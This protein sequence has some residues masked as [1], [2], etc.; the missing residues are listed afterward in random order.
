MV[1]LCVCVC[2][3][4]SFYSYPTCSATSQTFSVEK[5]NDLCDLFHRLFRLSSFD[6][7]FV[8][9]VFFLVRESR[10]NLPGGSDRRDERDEQQDVP[11]PGKRVESGRPELRRHDPPLCKTIAQRRTTPNVKSLITFFNSDLV[12]N[13]INSTTFFQW[14]N[15]F[16]FF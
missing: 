8:L 13:W 11:V 2:F 3:F 12:I 14:H 16:F 1:M 6:Y 4:I 5:R 10:D 15:E 9:F 7:T